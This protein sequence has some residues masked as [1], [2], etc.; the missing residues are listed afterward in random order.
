[1]DIDTAIR[2]L[3]QDETNKYLGIHKGNGMQHSKIKEHI[4][5][6]CYRQLR[7]ILKTEWNSAN[8]IEAITTLAS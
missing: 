1:M 7:A 8:R 3:D 2:E 4:R 5:K 6:E